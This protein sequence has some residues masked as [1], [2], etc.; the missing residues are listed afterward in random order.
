[1]PR[2]LRSQFLFIN[3]ANRT[4]GKPYEFAVDLG[5]DVSI[6]C[7]QTEMLSISLN[8]FSIFADWLTTNPTNRV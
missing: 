1:M 6:S 5:A 3:S 2:T 8:D 4:S 7:Q